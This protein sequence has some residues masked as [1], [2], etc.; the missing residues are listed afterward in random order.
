M[1]NFGLML[2]LVNDI[3][4]TV[5]FN[6]LFRP[7]G[8]LSYNRSHQFMPIGRRKISFRLDAPEEVI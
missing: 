8:F 3:C 6:E 2:N 1:K 7:K 5:P 4:K